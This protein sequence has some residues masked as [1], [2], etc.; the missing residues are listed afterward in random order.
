L[1]GL[2]AGRAGL[3]T[4][5][6]FPRAVIRDTADAR[7]ANYLTAMP[8]KP[9]KLDTRPRHGANPAVVRPTTAER[10]YGAVWKRTRKAK[11]AQSPLCEDCAE[12]GLTCG[13]SE[14]DHK[15]GKGPNGPRGHDM[16][17]LRSL[18]KSCHSR[19]TV[20]C[21]GGLGHHKRRPG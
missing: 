6:P 9:P 2:K 1:P 7:G 12:R 15:D 18:C 14:V 11:L 13:A 10:G 19:K 21:D 3:K 17:N 4:R 20:E 16:D 5:P 8:R